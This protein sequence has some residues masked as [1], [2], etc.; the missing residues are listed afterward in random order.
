MNRTILNRKKML[1]LCCM[2][3]HEVEHV[4]ITEEN[5]FKEVKVEYQAEYFYCGAAEEFY[6]DAEQMNANDVAMKNAYRR[7]VGLLTT[8]D[9]CGVRAK[10]GISQGDLCLLLGWG[11]KTITRYEGHQVQDAAHDTILRKLDGDP[12][13]FLTLLET[14][15]A[16]LPEDA[17]RRYVTIATG[18]YEECYDMYLR[19]AIHAQYAGY[20]GDSMKNGRRNLSLDRVV[21]VIRYFSNA[22]QVLSLYKVKLMKLLWYADAL[23]YKRRGHAITGLVYQA[24]PM[25]AVPVGHDSI[26]ELRGVNYEE[27]DMGNGTAYFF[28][29]DES[30]EYKSLS[31]EDIAILDDVIRAFGSRSKDEIVQAMHQEEAYKKTPMRAVISFEH[32]KRLSI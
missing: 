20:N 16:T 24:L 27:I 23:S 22:K 19:K 6:A 3:E 1:C 25:G 2:E 21:D 9:I 17:Y 18:L 5:I 8:E 30:I 13:W 7:K 31:V 15:R 12:E 28:C 29:G 4:R 10:Y 26:I 11:G 14:T 32:A